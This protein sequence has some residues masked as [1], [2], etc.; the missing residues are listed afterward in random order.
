VESDRALL[1]QLPDAEVT[2]LV[3]PQRQQLHDQLW[4]QPW[5]ILFFAGHSQTIGETGRLAINPQDSLTIAELSY[6]LQR[7]I[8]QGLQLAIFNSCDG[9]GL[10]HALENLQ[11]PQM[12]VMREPVPDRVAQGFLCYFLNAFAAGAPLHLAVREA[13]ERLQGLEKEF[14]GASGLPIL[15]Q[16][17]NVV[18][19]TWISLT[20]DSPIPVV[21]PAPPRRLP[22]WQT[23]MLVSFF[24]TS[25]L[26]G[27]RSLGWFQ[28]LEL[29]VFD[30]W[31]RLRPPESVDD[32]ILVITVDEADIQY[33][34]ER[35][36]IRRGSLSDQ[37]L[38]QLLHKLLP[39]QPSVIGL[40][41]FHDFEFSLDRSVLK[42]VPLIAT[43][44][45]GATA[46]S[47]S[48][49]A[50]PP[51]LTEEALGFSD[52]PVDPHYI[53]RRQFLGMT[54]AAACPTSQS[55]S[56]QVALRY[57][58]QQLTAS[59][60][61]QAISL[62]QRTPDGK[63]QIG[64]I[65]FPKLMGNTGGYQ[66]H[67]DEAKGYQ[68][69][70]NY[71]QA[72]LQQLSLTSLLESE[73]DAQLANWVRDRIILIGVDNNKDAH[74]TPYS[75]GNFAARMP[76]VIVQAQMVSQIIHAVLEERPL[77]RG[78]PRWGEVILMGLWAGIGGLLGW[79]MQGV[80]HETSRS[81]DQSW[82]ASGLM[83]LGTIAI[84]IAALIVLWY[85]V[86]FGMLLLGWWLPF[87]S[88]SLSLVLSSGSMV[89]WSALPH[90]NSHLPIRSRSS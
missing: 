90:A 27:M 31:L 58:E 76:G 84:L 48:G 30:Q 7:A 72:E 16:A 36:M 55:F 21:L 87:V 74:F 65:V 10:I 70:L 89:M 45:I 51:G 66:L 52:I 43:C 77:L 25:V 60:S 19:P 17:A 71:R 15:S 18:P 40:D 68:V 34:D 38:A 41:I 35:G 23:L 78:L 57:L 11:L 6:G 50:A 59:P 3:E 33:Q 4:E 79:R 46:E 44:E 13:R 47:P 75:Q 12:I 64:K 62:L 28:S 8:S 56:L 2:F 37:A 69:L 14:P 82:A 49:I 63:V 29:Q 42:T 32:R 22:P 39:H 9:L 53:I 85:G 86:G 81:I 83:G 24:V 61:K 20:G 54:S 5:H 26:T 73:W 67:P 80:H 1:N 88:T